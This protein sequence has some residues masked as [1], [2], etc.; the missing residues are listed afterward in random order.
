LNK[1]LS[2]YMPLVDAIAETFGKNCEV[3]LHDFSEPDKSIIKIA[4]GHLTGRDIG[5]PATGFVL[6]LLNRNNLKKDYFV[7]YPTKAQSG[8]ELKSTT[9]LIRDT[10]SKVVGA[11]C[12][13]IDITPYISTKNLL[14]E[15]CAMPFGQ[16][17][18]IEGESCEKFV[19]S[20]TALINDQLD[21]SMKKI[22]KPV[23]HMGKQDKLNIIKDLKERGI[24]LIKGSSK[25]ISK[26]L[27]VSLATIYK[28]LEEI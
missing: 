9:V 25:K 6:S 18:E 11:L 8:A 27:N 13:N 10:K 21:Q 15:L 19:S 20:T 12:I 5:S 3:V 17:S 22:G 1:Y 24:F 14:D 4:N 16:N 2:I 23:V 28:Y 26:E 7:G